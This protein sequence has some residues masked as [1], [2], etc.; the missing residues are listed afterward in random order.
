M[1]IEGASRDAVLLDGKTP[2]FFV[3][4]GD[5]FNHD[6]WWKQELVVSTGIYQV[7]ILRGDKETWSGSV[8]VPANQRVVIDVRL[9]PG[10]PAAGAA[11]TPIPYRSNGGNGE[12][13]GVE[14]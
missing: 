8:D 5:E 2:D 11:F 4:H 10:P 14:R 13:R 3:G 12:W 1:T 7:M 6:W 9:N